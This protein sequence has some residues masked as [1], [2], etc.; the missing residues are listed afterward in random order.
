LVGTSAGNVRKQ[1]SEVAGGDGGFKVSDLGFNGTPFKTSVDCG[2]GMMLFL[3]TK[4]WKCAQL[5]SPGFADLDGNILA[6]AG[7]GSGGVD[8]YEGYYRM[9]MDVYCGVQTQTVS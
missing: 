5:E 2:R 8:A 7:I 3:H 6:R 4:V 9:Y 1:A